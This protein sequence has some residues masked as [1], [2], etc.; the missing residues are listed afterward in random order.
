MVGHEQH[1]ELSRRSSLMT[2]R[3]AILVGLELLRHQTESRRHPEMAIYFCG[4]W[5]YYGPTIFRGFFR[6]ILVGFVRLFHAFGAQIFL[7]SSP[8]GRGSLG[9]RS[10]RPNDQLGRL[11]RSG[12]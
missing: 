1:A 8:A 9:W 10:G 11:I 5:A 2:A 12:H 4:I 3:A 6:G 7:C